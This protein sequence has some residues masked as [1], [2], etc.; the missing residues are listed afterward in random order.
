VN[1]LLLLLPSVAV[2]AA[3]VLVTRLA[4]RLRP[5]MAAWALAMLCVAVVVASTSALVAVVVDQ[6]AAVP[7]LA[8]RIGWCARVA[9]GPLAVAAVAGPLL[10]VTWATV[11]LTRAARR[12]RAD[13]RGF[14]GDP[15]IIVPS[16][17]VV[18]LAVPGRLGR[19]GQIVVTTGMLDVLDAEERSAM[20][21]HEIAH[22]HLRHHLFLRVSG[23]AAAALPLLRPVHRRVRFATERWA[24]ERAARDVGSR[25][26]VARAVAKG[27]LAAAGE[28][29]RLGQAM[30]LNGGST[31]ER[32]DAL[33]AVGSSTPGPIQAAFGSVAVLA[34]GLAFAQV[35]HLV[36]LAL[37]AC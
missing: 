37:H 14:G 5:W 19:P 1:L 31:G 28:P 2:I 22:L 13:T 34:L 27:A 23:L 11:N 8:E 9:G 3:T 6:L 7:W 29:L 17:A 35:H 12:Q 18:A 30:A 25:S 33:L 26:L 20:F 15:V 4:D 10:G 32:V 16:P 36:G 21:A 24:D